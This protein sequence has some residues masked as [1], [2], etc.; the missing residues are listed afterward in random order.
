MTASL[1]RP[2][3]IADDTAVFWSAVTGAN[4]SAPQG[5]RRELMALVPVSGDANLRVRRLGPAP[6]GDAGPVAAQPVLLDLHSADP[7][8]LI[9]AA[10]GLGAVVADPPGDGRS[11]LHSPGGL[12]L[13]VV[14]HHGECE[15]PAPAPLPGG[16]G[17]VRVDQLCLDVPSD[18]YDDEVRFWSALLDRRT[19]TS[20]GHP[21]FTVIRSRDLGFRLLIQRLDA[22]DPRR[23][24]TAH[25]DL[26]SDDVAATVRHHRRLGA[27]AVSELPRWTV[28]TDPSGVPYCVTA[29]SV[30]SGEPAP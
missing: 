24:V 7:A 26:A 1:D 15:L 23:P 21:E 8:G 10:T 27:S 9:A 25:L 29:R 17:R 19:G 18:R 11:A 2:A 3:N 13:C 12:P 16:A 4:R 20:A 28:M 22:A 5:P 6:A 30:E 14:G